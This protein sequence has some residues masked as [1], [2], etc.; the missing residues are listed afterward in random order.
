MSFEK[1]I[2]PVGQCANLQVTAMIFKSCK[3]SIAIL[4]FNK[5]GEACCLNCKFFKKK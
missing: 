5:V 3:D 4:A 1:T 2:N